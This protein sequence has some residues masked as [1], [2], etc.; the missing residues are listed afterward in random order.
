MSRT[1]LPKGH[2]EQTGAVTETTILDYGENGQV[3]RKSTSTIEISLPPN[4]FF[5]DF[6]YVV[7]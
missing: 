6:L 7:L 1:Y 5:L 2:N 3:T 4:P